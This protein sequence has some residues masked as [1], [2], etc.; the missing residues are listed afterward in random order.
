MAL[1]WIISS[2]VIWPVAIDSGFHEFQLWCSCDGSPPLGSAISDEFESGVS[3]ALWG[4]DAVEGCSSPLLNSI[5]G[6]GRFKL[7]R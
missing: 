6:G 4:D 2:S 1:S 5:A 3:G 7:T